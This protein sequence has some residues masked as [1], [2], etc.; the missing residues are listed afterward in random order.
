MEYEATHAS[1]AEPPTAFEERAKVL[2]ERVRAAANAMLAQGI[3]PTVARLRAA[4]GG[5]SPNDLAPALKTWRLEA[6]LGSVVGR[7][8]VSGAGSPVPTVIADLATELWRRAQAAAILEAR[9]GPSSLERVE[10]S[11]ETRALRTQLEDLRQQADRDAQAYGELRAQA[12]RHEAL[13]REALVRARLS[14]TRERALLR[15]L[16]TARARITELEATA[17]L[18]AASRKPKETR[19]PAKSTA[20]VPSRKPRAGQPSRAPE[21]GRL[22]PSR[23]TGPKRKRPAKRK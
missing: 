19:I 14:E 21:K 7:A 16:G 18:A 4:L 3:S 17:T 12:A 6:G 10:R 11:A 22:P 13:A 15:D 20:R 9:S 1:Q 5:G 23:T 8:P 2:H